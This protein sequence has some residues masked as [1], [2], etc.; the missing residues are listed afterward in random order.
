MNKKA[1]L[2]IGALASVLAGCDQEPTP[3]E[4]AAYVDEEAGN[5]TRA[6]LAEDQKDL[7]ATVKEL[8]SKDP[9]VKD[10]YYSYNEKGEK[11]LHIVREEANGKNSDSVWPM[12]G[13][14]AVGALG[15]YALAKA[16][17]SQGGYN[18]YQNSHPPMSQAHYDEEERR[19]HRNTATA[20]YTN[21]M[22]NNNRG[23]VR[24]S[25]T[26]RQNMASSVSNYRSGGSYSSSGTTSR[27]SGIMSGGGGGRSAAHG[28]GGS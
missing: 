26:Y 13:G 3:A 15:G 7:D 18:S 21:M 17:N 27:A 5:T 25:P 16:M 14:A 9:S 11:V 2:I 19:K 8:Q 6:Q 12:L 10:A 28:G 20:G 23:F 22:M 24:Q 1:F 4:E